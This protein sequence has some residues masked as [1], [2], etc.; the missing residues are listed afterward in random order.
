MIIIDSTL[1]ML[2][3]IDIKQLTYIFLTH[4]LEDLQGPLF[5]EFNSKKNGGSADLIS[6]Q[7]LKLG[8]Q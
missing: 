2:L 1:D 7:S 4:F 6:E 3:S 5:L 8:D